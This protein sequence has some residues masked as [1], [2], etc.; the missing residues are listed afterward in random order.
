MCHPRL[1]FPRSFRT[2]CKH[3]SDEGYSPDMFLHMM[4]PQVTPP[5]C[6]HAHQMDFQTYPE[7]ENIPGCCIPARPQKC[8]N[9]INKHFNCSKTRL[10]MPLYALQ[11][12]THTSKLYNHQ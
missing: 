2:I 6:S 8:A 12:H 3:P 11:K 9:I 10:S 5:D 4:P 7:R 1:L